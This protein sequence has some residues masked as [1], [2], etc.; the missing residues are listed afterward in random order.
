MMQA[1]SRDMQP[2]KPADAAATAPASLADVLRRRALEQPEKLAYTFLLDGE[3][4]EGRFTYGDLDRKARAVAA[5]LQEAAPP[6]ARVLL[7]VPQGLEFIASFFGCL[8]AGAIAVPAN[9]P[10]LHRS[11]PRLRS[12]LAD[13]D[14]SLVLT[15]SSLL[16]RLRKW[17]SDLPEAQGLRF[18][19]LD[20]IDPVAAERWCPPNLDPASI[21]F[22][23]YTSGSTS[24]PKGVMVTHRNLLHNSSYIHAVEENGPDSV[25]ATWLPSFHDMGLIEGVLQPV[26]GGFPCY[27]MSPAAF[28][29][30][31][32]RWLRAIHR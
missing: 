14:P 4:E 16:P 12:V 13:S 1:E 2:Q 18:L 26:Y 6:G 11:V 20:L 7:L 8:Y 30:Q 27:L 9:L 23:Q 5:A 15:T 21:A 19:A 32:L 24:S 22:L 31:P 29:Q 17:L 3:I 10:R 25:S 28:L